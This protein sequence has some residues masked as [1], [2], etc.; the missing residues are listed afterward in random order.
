M[1]T[2]CLELCHGAAAK[3]QNRLLHFLYLHLYKSIYIRLFNLYFYDLTHAGALKPER[4][5]REDPLREMTKPGGAETMGFL[6]CSSK[7]SKPT[8][9]L[10]KCALYFHWPNSCTAAAFIRLSIPRYTVIIPAASA[11]RSDWIHGRK[12]VFRSH[13]EHVPLPTHSNM[14]SIWWHTR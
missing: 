13:A 10:S 4:D 11:F 14:H 2:C 6:F 7:A 12:T 9:I 8:L 1:R 5:E 3:L